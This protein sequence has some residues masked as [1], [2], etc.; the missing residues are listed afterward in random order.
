MVKQQVESVVNGKIRCDACPVMCYIA[1]G[2]S[3]ACDR[4]ANVGGD[5]VRVD[6]LTIIEQQVA[7][8]G[9]VVP[10]APDAEAGAWDGDLVHARTP[11]VTAVGAGTTYPDYKPAPFI[12]SQR[13]NGVDMVTVVTEGIFSY[14]GVKVKIDT[15][16]FVGPEMAVV[17]VDDEPVG[18]V[19]TGEYGSQMLSLGGVH[20]LTGGGKK[21]GRVTCEAL[22]KLCNRERVELAVEGG[23]MLSI[24]A[25]QPPVINGIEETRMRVGCGSAAIGIFARQ[26]R[27]LVDEVVVVDD[28]ITGVL[29]EHQAGKLLDIPPTGIRI[30]GR[31]STPG[32][33]FQVAEPGTGWGGTN[34]TDPLAILGDFDPKVA[35][36]G[37]RLLMV[38]TTGDQSGYYVLDE[39]LRPVRQPV[40]PADLQAAVDVVAE[41]CEPAMVSVLFVGGAGG[42]LRAGVTTNPVRLTRSVKDALTHVSCGGA[43]AYVWPGGGITVMADVMQMPTNSFGYVPTPA[44]VAPIEFTMR[45]DDYRALGGHMEAVVPIEA[46]VALAER[47]IAPIVEGAWPTAERNFKWGAGRS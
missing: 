42:S 16:R 20:H 37:M 24:Q 8:G 2:R 27:D 43:P 34:I 44:L 19:T 22:L 17:R 1:D 32:R 23:A 10:F 31:R 18:H 45:L 46:A 9:S 35:R 25:G 13:Q 40:L 36:P 4:Y 21:E 14:C 12:V 41:N 29:S 28:H 30:K 5:L 7:H 39:A 33:Y 11:F 26:W 6:P 15:D 47:T 3:G 38:S